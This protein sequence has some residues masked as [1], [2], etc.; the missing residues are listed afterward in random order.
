MNSA[1]FWSS[2]CGSYRFSVSPNPVKGNMNIIFDKPIKANEN[3][4][5]KLY[6][7]NSSLL[8]KQW[9]LK[10]GQNQ[11]SLN[12]SDLKSGHYVLEVIIGKSKSSKQII[13][14]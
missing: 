1:D 14:E 9:T 2:Y 3:V 6:S 11:F 5:M 12:V 13:I 8:V 10:G 7:L 4:L